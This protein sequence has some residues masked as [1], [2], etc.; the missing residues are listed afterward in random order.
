MNTIIKKEINDIGY[1][2]IKEWV[3]KHS[4]NGVPNKRNMEY[5]CQE[6]EEG[7]A[8][9][10]CIVELSHT[11]SISGRTETFKVPSEGVTISEYDENGDLI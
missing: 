6:A 10:D 7:L 5:W 3:T 4:I 8:Q 9:V 11:D 1:G 2:L